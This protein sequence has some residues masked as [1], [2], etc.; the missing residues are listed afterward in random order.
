MRRWSDQGPTRRALLLALPALAAA[1][2]AA[3]QPVVS[4]QE[5]RRARTVVQEWD[6]SCGAAALAT[7]LN[8]QHGDPIGEREIALALV[9][10]ERYLEQPLL[11]R[12]RNGF[13]LLDLKRFV[14]ARG[15]RGIGY[16]GLTLNDL[17]E[18]APIMVPVNSRGYRHFVV[19]RGR[20]GDRVL[21]SDPAF[22]TRTLTAAAF[23]EVWLELE[24]LGRV[25]FVVSR[26]DEPS[27]PGD[28]APRPEEFPTLG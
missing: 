14:E 1:A 10:Q 22:G 12:I 28:L 6:L 11:V 24:E 7:I 25:G 5:M 15:Y 4:L 17:V 8:H 19:F 23:E 20:M 9:S 27:P 2:P 21:L 13:S 16:G 26:G 18:R 3:A